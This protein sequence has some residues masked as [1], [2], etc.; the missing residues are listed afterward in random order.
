MMLLLLFVTSDVAEA[1]LLPAE[2]RIDEIRC[3]GTGASPL[4][5]NI[6]AADA[7]G[8]GGGGAGLVR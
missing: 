8:T 5:F 2:L 3:G 1:K 4:E 7:V 6:A